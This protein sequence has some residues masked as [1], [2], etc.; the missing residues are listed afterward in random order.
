VKNN[1]KIDKKVD[2]KINKQKTLRIKSIDNEN[3]S[4]VENS[5]SFSES[6]DVL[7]DKDESFK[8]KKG[9]KKE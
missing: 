5:R 2:K 8:D 4:I 9:I 3:S 7:N 1:K 6:S